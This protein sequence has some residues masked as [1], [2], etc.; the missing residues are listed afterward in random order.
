MAGARVDATFDDVT[1]TAIPVPDQ[2]WSLR[3]SVW[4][5][6]QVEDD[7]VR[8]VGEAGGPGYD[9]LREAF[10]AVHDNDG[11]FARGQADRGRL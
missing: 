11:W 9:W 5:L 3:D 1:F 7:A 10:L 4:T 8:R 2:F 6:Q